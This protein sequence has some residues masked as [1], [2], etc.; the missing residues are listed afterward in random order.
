MVKYM[1]T[2]DWMRSLRIKAFAIR[3]ISHDSIFSTIYQIN[4]GMNPEEIASN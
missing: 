1:C 3:A 2:C 4:G